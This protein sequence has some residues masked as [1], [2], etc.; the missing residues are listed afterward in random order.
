MRASLGGNES[1]RLS[2][3]ARRRRPPQT[4]RLTRCALSRE[5]RSAQKLLGRP[6]RTPKEFLP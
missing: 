5:V 2:A 3:E 1:C 6:V 4:F